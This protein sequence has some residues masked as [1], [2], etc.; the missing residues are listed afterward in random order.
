MEEH[1]SRIYSSWFVVSFL[2]DHSVKPAL[3]TTALSHSATSCHIE[4]VKLILGV[5]VS[6]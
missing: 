3:F 2:V 5:R 6:R 1:G 4:D